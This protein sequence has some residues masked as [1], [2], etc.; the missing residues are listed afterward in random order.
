M[1]QI[2]P[3]RALRYNPDKVDPAK[4]VAPPYDV[5]DEDDR[6][7][8]LARD[9]H[10]IV[11]LT[12]GDEPLT[13]EPP[14]S[15]YER[16]AELLRQWVAEG[17]LIHDPQPALY[18]WEQT[19]RI[20]PGM[21]GPEGELS[22]RGFVCLLK[23][24]P[25]GE[26]TVFPHEGTLSAP[27][28]DRLNLRRACQAAFSPIFL[29]YTDPERRTEEA[30]AAA[31]PRPHCH[32]ERS[33]GSRAD[34][35]TG[36][37]ST[38]F[39]ASLRMTHGAERR[40]GEPF[41]PAQPGQALLDATDDDG[42]HHRV[43]ALGDP[44]AIQ[45]VQQALS[46][47]KLVIADG[48]HRYETA[49][50]YRDQ[51]RKKAGLPDGPWEYV[52]AYL[53]NTV[54]N[55]V[56][57][58]PSHRVLRGVPPDVIASLPARAREFFSVERVPLRHLRGD[59]LAQARELLSRLRAAGAG[60]PLFGVYTGSP[61][62][63]LLRARSTALG[64]DLLPDVPPAARCLDIVLLHTIVIDR[65][66]GVQLQREEPGRNIYFTRGADKVI[67][68]VDTGG[69]RVGLLVSPARVEQVMQLGLA[70]E[71]MPQ[72]GTYFYPKLLSGAVMYDMRAEPPAT[73]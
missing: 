50:N 17:I 45:A 23:L 54:G 8:Y 59:R 62:A 68:W 60:P 55:E 21:L 70:G 43:F 47:Q 69:G 66:L 30:L 20:P 33:E 36:E 46:G 58:L 26:G 56:T 52:L 48:H 35:S 11:R 61:E 12:L 40:A 57:I 27:K 6:L 65:L 44:R 25:L 64:G 3:L 63:L 42:T 32:P 19:Y 53:C 2:K 13:P 39:F 71:R 37:T 67:R 4:V 73:E 15:R 18:V 1:A 38:R 5:L 22:R 28:A 7:A 24:E 72:K 34:G 41:A 29:I 9:E 51:M 16:A 14:P 10:N 31:L 49:L